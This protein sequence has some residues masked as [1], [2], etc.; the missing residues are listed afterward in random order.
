MESR[1]LWSGKKLQCFVDVYLKRQFYAEII[2]V[3]EISVS[4]S[5]V[6]HWQTEGQILSEGG[7]STWYGGIGFPYDESLHFART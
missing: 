7:V 3:N 5:V 1:Q 4:C 6:T 2:C